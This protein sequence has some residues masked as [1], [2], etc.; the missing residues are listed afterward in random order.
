MEIHISTQANNTNYGTYLFWHGLGARRVVS[1]RELSLAE[2]REIRDHIPQDMQIESFIHGAMCIS[3]SGRCLLS[4]YFV[5]RDANQG[6]CTHP[7]RWKYAVVEETRPGEYMPIYENERGTFIFNSGDLCMIEHIPEMLEAGI[8]SFKI[9]GRMKQRAY[10]AGVVS[11]YRRYVDQYLEKG[12]K[13]YHVSEKDRQTLLDLGNRSGF[14]DGY[15]AGHVG[16]EMM[17]FA[18]GSHR[19]EQ[20]EIL[21]TGTEIRRPIRGRF[22]AREGRPMRLTVSCDGITLERESSQC[23]ERARNRATDEEVVA[24]KL[25]KTGDTPFV[26]ADLVIDLEPGLFI[27]MTQVNELRRETWRSGGDAA[28]REPPGAGSLC[29]C[30]SGG[31]Y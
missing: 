29:A 21:E 12:R 3:Y 6:A 17:S 8:D 23:P 27:P 11:I 5:G 9:E 10:A 31:G 2:I 22:F 26:F 16:R 13:G 18:E 24:E 14:T 30:R 20:S 19:K 15:L 25:K 1:A 4:N 7:C 28:R